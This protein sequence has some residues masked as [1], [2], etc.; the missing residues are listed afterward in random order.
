VWERDTIRK[1]ASRFPK[2]VENAFYLTT[3]YLTA[4]R[5]AHTALLSN[6]ASQRLAHVLAGLAN[7]I[8]ER[9][10]NGIELRVRNEELANE[11]NITMFTAS[12]LLNEWQRAGILLKKRGKI[13]LRAPERL[14]RDAG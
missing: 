7:G 6:S 3:Q 2:L 13:V 11:A 1:L 5:V 4:Y 14:L 9:S 8:G 12:R 10:A